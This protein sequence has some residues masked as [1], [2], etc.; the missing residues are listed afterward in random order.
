MN[1]S[2]ISVRYAKALFE[3]AL[4]RELLEQTKVDMTLILEVS[5]LT[6]FRQLTDNPT[7]PPSKKMAIFN[8]TFRKHVN[9]LTL[10][11]AG[12]VFKN[13]R[14]EY[15][16]AIARNFVT[17]SKK[18]LGIAEVTLTTAYTTDRKTSESIRKEVARTL[19]TNIDMKEKVDSSI[20]GGFVIRVE[21][22]LFDASVREKLRR[23][24][25]EMM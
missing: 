15:L 6:E 3:A 12:L 18:H 7:I 19:D 22:R 24:K 25:K 16:P 14:E 11:L 5:S 10:D 2:R 23:I 20:I 13:R 21:D 8:E 9:H 4:E 17:M 1:E